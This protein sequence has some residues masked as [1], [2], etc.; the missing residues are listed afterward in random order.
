MRITQ[1]STIALFTALALLGCGNDKNSGAQDGGNALPDLTAGPSPDLL[2]ADLAPSPNGDLAHSPTTGPEGVPP[3]PTY[4][5]IGIYVSPSGNDATGD[6]SEAKP[7]KTISHV[8][9]EVAEAGDTIILR[10]GEFPEAVRVRLPNITIRSHSGE[11]ATISQ[12][13]TIDGNDPLLPVM[14][15]VDADG[16]KLQRVE[17]KGGFYGV[18]LQTK[19]DWGD[20]D[21]TMGATNIT[22]EDSIIHDTGRDCIKVTPQ[23]DGLIVR[24]TEI[25]HSGMGYPDGTAPDDKNAEGIDVV[26]ADNVL[27]QDCYI[28]DTATTGVYLKGGSTN[29]IIERTRVIHTGALGIVLGFDT[30]P[31]FFDLVTNPGYYENIDGIVRNCIIEDTRY[32]GLAIYAAKNPKLINNTIVD[33]AHAAHAPIYLG[34]TLQDYDPAAG[35]PANR[36]PVIVNNLVWQPSGG[37]CVAIRF[38]FEEDELGKLDGLDPAGSITIDNNLYYAATGSC[39]FDDAREGGVTDVA[40][41]AWATHIGGE[42]ASLT[43]DPKL[44]ADRHLDAGSAAIDKGQARA[45]VS[46]DFDRQARSGMFDIGA[47][48]RQ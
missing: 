37:A 48:E 14:F 21:D 12:P 36:D 44:T 3:A 45:E 43:S 33:T 15:D 9:A 30:S 1:G 20:P 18:M 46:F 25:H 6:G 17:V 27:V 28:H 7:Y 24:R 16:G 23:S 22:I 5:D 34:V 32:A 2:G 31:E 42:A 29:G 35:R 19:W 40:L 47:D 13:I 11:L 8:L 39:S 26:N 4:D 10:A 41:A 38:Y